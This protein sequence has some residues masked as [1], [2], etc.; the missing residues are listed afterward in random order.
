MNSHKTTIG[1]IAA[2]IL[3]VGSGLYYFFQSVP[4]PPPEPVVEKQKTDSEIQY[5]G[6]ALSETKDGK[7]Q[8][9]LK[10]DQMQVGPDQKTVSLSGLH[11]QTYDAAGQAKIQLTANQG[12][13]DTQAKVVTIQGNIKAISD[14]GA[15]L[16]GNMLKW[17]MNERRFIGE[18]NIQYRQKDVTIMGDNLEADQDLN[19]IRVT[20]NARAELRR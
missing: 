5:L 10:A 20:G 4:E 13:M 9:E 7:L 16:A 2:A 11:A 15:E 8:W 12:D 6:T 14:K 18:G 1:I 3:L 17:F 19:T